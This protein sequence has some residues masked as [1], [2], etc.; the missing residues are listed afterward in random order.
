EGQCRSLGLDGIVRFLGR[1]SGDDLVT[2]Y[3]N[4]AVLALPSSNDSFPVVLLEAM[5]CG[6]PV[7]ST[8]VGGIP[9]LVDDGRTGYLVAPGEWDALAERLGRIVDDPALAHR[10]GRTARDMAEGTLTCE[11]QVDRT[12]RIFTAVIAGRPGEGSHRLAIVAPYFY[13]KF[14]GLEN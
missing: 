12:H 4:A 6:L 11:R 7:V 14:G 13:P 3:R 1:L 9:G 10:L 5:A 2:A 8:K